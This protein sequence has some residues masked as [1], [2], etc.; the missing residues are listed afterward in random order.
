MYHR[1]QHAGNNRSLRQGYTD[2][3]LLVSWLHEHCMVAPITFSVIDADFFF[4][5][6]KMCIT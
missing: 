6:T 4:L 1:P 2:P 3:W 5:H